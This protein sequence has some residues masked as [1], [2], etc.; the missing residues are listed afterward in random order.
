MAAAGMS[1]IVGSARAAA[2]VGGAF[3][4]SASST[5]GHR[6]RGAR[7][8]AA[9]VVLQISENCVAHHGALEPIARAC[10]SIADRGRRAGRGA[11]GPRHPRTW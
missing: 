1:E 11:P 4:A 5:R 10:L 2:G 7:A 6:G 9:P 3:N 8:A